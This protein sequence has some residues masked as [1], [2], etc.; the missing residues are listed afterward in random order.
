MKATH[1]STMF[2][3]MPHR[4]EKIVKIAMPVRNIV[5]RPKSSLNLAYIVR[6][7]RV[8]TPWAEDGRNYRTLTRVSQEVS[9]NNPFA[10]GKAIESIGDRH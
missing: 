7:P 4:I 10:K 9:G 2:V 6:K 5:L 3:E 1:S 8:I